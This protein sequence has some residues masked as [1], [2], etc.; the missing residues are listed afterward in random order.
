M[1]HHG[2]PGALVSHAQLDSGQ[3][4]AVPAHPSVPPIVQKASQLGDTVSERI[5][6]VPC[7]LTSSPRVQ[8]AVFVDDLGLDFCGDDEDEAR[9]GM[10][11]SV[12]G[13]DKVLVDDLQLAHEKSSVVA[14]SNALATTV[15][16][17]LEVLTSGV[18]SSARNLGIDLSLAKWAAGCPVSA[19]RGSSKPDAG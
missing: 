18:V 3:H 19:G 17:D 14:W 4:A 8:F 13:L 2:S 7:H 1:Q 9:S 10:V 15:A 12:T 5:I 11:E 16:R 6:S